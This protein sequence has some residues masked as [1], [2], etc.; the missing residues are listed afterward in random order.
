MKKN[1]IKP[2]P[3]PQT[4]QIVNLSHDGK[5]VARINGKATFIPGALA[6]ERVEFHYTKIKKDFDEGQL[7]SVLDASPLRVTPRCPHYQLCGGCSLQHLDPEQ[8]IH[9][10][11]EQL[12]D[13]L[14]RLGQ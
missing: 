13:L 2:N 12:L 10:K 14:A 11:Q 1:R 4:T 7:L 8:Q 5:G 3:T 9:F 6:Q